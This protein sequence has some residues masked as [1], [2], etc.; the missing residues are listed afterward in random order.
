[1]PER[2]LKEYIETA[3]STEAFRKEELQCLEDVLAAWLKD[4]GSE[5]T[6][7]SSSEEGELSG[8][9]IY[10]KIPMTEHSY[11]LYWIVVSPAHQRKGIGRRLIMEMEKYIL[12]SSS[13]GIIR[14]ETSGK[15]SYEGQREFYVNLGYRESGRIP[16]FYSEG[17]DLVTFSK[18]IQDEKA[19]DASYSHDEVRNCSE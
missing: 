7:L 13:M 14:I 6:L 10:G 12:T 4:P 9:L 16:D 19:Y 3:A 17:D 15:S 18:M 5:Y 8:F 11:D 2:A 1:M